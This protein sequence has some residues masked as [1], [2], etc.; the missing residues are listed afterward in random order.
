MPVRSVAFTDDDSML[1]SGSDD[2]RIN[3]FNVS[4]GHLTA[5]F[6]GHTSWVTSVV[7]HPYE[8][9][10]ASSS[11]DGTVRI[12]DLNTKNCQDIFDHQKDSV[13]DLSWCTELNY[14]CSVTEQGG[15]RV[16]Q[17]LN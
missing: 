2:S 16:F 9:L 11:T 6:T 7:P 14:L 8:P 17:L 1:Y 13:W 15:L 5:T 12:W 4:H 10:L 3:L